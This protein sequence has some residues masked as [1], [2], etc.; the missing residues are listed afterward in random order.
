ML[1]SAADAELDIGA[2]S[3]C[4]T[5]PGRCCLTL[6]L[7]KCVDEG[8]SRAKWRKTA[9]QLVVTMPIAAADK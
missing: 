2:R 7:P 1:A 5:V 3:L 4:V 6:V 9:S 8:G